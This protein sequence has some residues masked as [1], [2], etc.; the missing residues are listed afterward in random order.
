MA[1]E[2]MVIVYLYLDHETEF[3]GS[4]GGGTNS[5]RQGRGPQIVFLI[6]RSIAGCLAG[7]GKKSL[8][9]PIGLHDGR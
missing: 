2:Y 7:I 4:F 5:R 8:G 9:V 3:E 1:I 6:G